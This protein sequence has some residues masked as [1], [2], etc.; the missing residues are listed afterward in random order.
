VRAF[1]KGRRLER[2]REALEAGPTRRHAQG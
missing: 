2:E 1:R